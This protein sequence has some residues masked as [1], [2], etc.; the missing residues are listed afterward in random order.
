MANPFLIP[1]IGSRN[2]DWYA[3]I[4]RFWHF[5]FKY[6][7]RVIF[8]SI[9]IL[10]LTPFRYWEKWRLR[11]K[12][13]D[14]S[15][16]EPPVFIIGHWRSGTT[17]L[18]NYLARDSRFTY[19]NY[20]HG[21]FPHCFLTI[22][23]L[24]WLLKTLAPA[25]RPMDNMEISTDAPQE[26]E[27]PLAVYGAYSAFT[28]W[29]FLQNLG[30][31][32]NRFVFFEQA[33]RN[34]IARWKENYLIILKKCLLLKPGIL[35]TKNPANS[36]RIKILLELF[37]EA[38]FI[39]IYRNPYR[40][41]LSTG[42]L[43]KKALPFFQL[44]DEKFHNVK[45]VY[46][47][48]Y[49]KLMDRIIHDSNSIPSQQLYSLRYESFTEDPV[50]SILSI[51]SHFSINANDQLVRNLN[52]YKASISNY[53]VNVFEQDQKEYSRIKEKFDRYFDHFNYE[54]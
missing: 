25:K 33:D 46:E 13:S 22:P 9:V 16:D 51:Y 49:S 17:M 18:H 29:I 26:E 21:L 28:G 47:G 20:L 2:R 6:L 38:R 10:V 53:K 42:K 1:L 45:S 48:V 52:E 39:H 8:V 3:Q 30:K 15:I 40:V 43:Y 11:K 5:S 23:W 35:L 41:L 50:G 34:Y 31:L 32:I 36:A 27:V 4:F 54:A 7:P 19:V 12:L 37:P 24:M 44:E 14:V